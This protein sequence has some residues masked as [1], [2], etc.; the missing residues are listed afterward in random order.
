MDHP[1]LSPAQHHVLTKYLEAKDQQRPFL[2]GEVFTSEAMFQS[3]FAFET[4]F[5]DERPVHG[6]DAIAGVF[7]RMGSRVENIFTVY[8]PS[9]VRWDAGALSID[10]LVG[11]SERE[12]GKL[13]LA[14]GDYAWRF[15][16]A[17]TRA[18]ELVVLMRQMIELPASAG[19]SINHW[20]AELPA[21]WCEAEQILES[22][23]SFAGS[24]DL[25]AFF[26][27]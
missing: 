20:L 8:T 9:S 10:W 5:N 19:S 25:R 7:Q 16:P 11:M 18:T 24:E 17:G 12:S 4:D 23:P 26:S 21:P 27:R 6:L 14:W 3:R 1:A 22:M 2:F 13:R 15:N